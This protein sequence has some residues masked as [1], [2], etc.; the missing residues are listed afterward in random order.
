MVFVTARKQPPLSRATIIKWRPLERL[1]SQRRVQH[2]NCRQMPKATRRVRLLDIAML[3]MA[4]HHGMLRQNSN[5]LVRVLISAKERGSRRRI[6]F[7]LQWHQQPPRMTARIRMRQ[8]RKQISLVYNLHKRL[9]FVWTWPSVGRV[10][11]RPVE[12]VVK[13]ANIKQAMGEQKYPEQ[14]DAQDAYREVIYSLDEFLPKRT[15]S[16]EWGSR[17]CWR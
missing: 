15:C 13:K 4:T 7:L 10:V 8:H 17:S 3:P 16:I 6:S 12:N 1:R 5:L 14:R 11:R 2:P 9:L